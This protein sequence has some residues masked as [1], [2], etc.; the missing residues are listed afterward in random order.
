MLKLHVHY[1]WGIQLKEREEKEAAA[2]SARSH[3][4]HFDF[5]ANR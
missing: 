3:P 2:S 1:V 4:L 5:S